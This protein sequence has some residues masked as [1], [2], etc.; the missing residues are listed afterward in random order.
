VGSRMA[1]RSAA[2]DRQKKGKLKALTLKL[3][4]KQ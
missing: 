1:K 4:L 3:L 2:I